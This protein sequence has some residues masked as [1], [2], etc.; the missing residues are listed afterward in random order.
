MCEPAP[1]LQ[2]SI[3][4]PP[5][6]Y[7]FAEGS[8]GTAP[9]SPDPRLCKGKNMA[10]AKIEKQQ[11]LGA[12]KATGSSDPDV[13]YARKEELLAESKRMKLLGIVPIIVGSVVS[14]TI[15]GAVVGIPA[16]IFGV[17]M[18]KRIRQNIE[19]AETGYAE[20]LKLIGAR[21]SAA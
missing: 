11:V 12:L 10:I 17:V 19:N 13:L 5:E 6:A 9:G 3:I 8:K 7:K 21:V 4:Q 15:I 14:I 20:Y 16:I 18:R 2:A 1:E